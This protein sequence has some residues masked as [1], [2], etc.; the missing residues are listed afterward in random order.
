MWFAFL[1]L[2]SGTKWTPSD[3]FGW[4]SLSGSVIRM[5]LGQLHVA[6]IQTVWRSAWNPHY[7][8]IWHWKIRLGLLMPQRSQP[9]PPNDPCHRAEGRKDWCQWTSH[10][11][12]VVVRESEKSVTYGKDGRPVPPRCYYKAFPSQL[13]KSVLNLREDG[14]S[15]GDSYKYPPGKSRGRTRTILKYSWNSLSISVSRIQV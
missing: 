14:V 3:D 6:L 11:R 9:L 8:K 12:K 2:N 5:P 15:R 1:S 7:K 10:V 4:L 13:F